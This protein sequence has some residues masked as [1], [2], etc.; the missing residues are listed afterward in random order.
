MTFIFNIHSYIKKTD[1]SKLCNLL[2]PV[3]CEYNLLH[4]KTIFPSSEA[5]LV[6]CSFPTGFYRRTICIHHISFSKVQHGN[7]GVLYCISL[8]FPLTISGLDRE[9]AGLHV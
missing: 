3:V 5:A 1:T 8:Y 4:S 7:R 2:Q 9:P 6:Q